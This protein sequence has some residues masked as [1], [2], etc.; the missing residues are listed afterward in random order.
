MTDGYR[1][2][3]LLADGNLGLETAVGLTERSGRT[4][5]VLPRYAR[6]PR[7]GRRGDAGGR[8]RRQHPLLR[9]RPRQ[10]AG[11]PRPGRDRVGR[12]APVRV[13]LAVQRCLRAPRPARRRHRLRRGR[14]RHHQ[15]R[16]QPAA[17][18]RTRRVGPNELLHLDVGTDGIALATLDETHVERRRPSRPLGAR[19][20]RDARARLSDDPAR[21]ARRPG[22]GPLVGASPQDDA[23]Q[24]LPPA[25]PHPADSARASD[26]APGPSTSPARH[27]WR[28][29]PGSRASRPRSASTPT[30]SPARGCS[31]FPARRSP[32]C[33]RPRSSGGSPGRAAC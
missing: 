5:H 24:V 30:T 11:Q 25:A 20:R 27:G 9:R 2:L 15:R 22:R 10:D 6:P 16:H 33:S 26:R 1:A 19:L 4:A 31:T 14:P 7:R 21:R 32:W 12:P 3:S 13:V 17:S 23:R 18:H 29:A 8:R 28:R